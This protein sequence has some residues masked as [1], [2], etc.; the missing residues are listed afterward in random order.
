M[1]EGG[2]GKK[3][4]M[5]NVKSFRMS[6]GGG[7]GLLLLSRQ[8]G[9]LLEDR[10]LGWWWQRE[11]VWGEIIIC[12]CSYAKKGERREVGEIV[13]GREYRIQFQRDLHLLEIGDTDTTALGIEVT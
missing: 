5:I 8:Y 1:R 4:G 10:I 6:R 7:K 9:Q 13:I 12:R 3:K 2:G 11:R